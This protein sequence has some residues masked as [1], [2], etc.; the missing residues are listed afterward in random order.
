MAIQTEHVG[1]LTLPM[2]DREIWGH[3]IGMQPQV[4]GRGSECDLRLFDP[5]VSRAHALIWAESDGAI[6]VSDLSSSNGVHINGERLRDDCSPLVS[7]DVLRLGPN[8]A[9]CLQ[10]CDSGPSPSGMAHQVDMEAACSF[11]EMMRDMPFDGLTSDDVHGLSWRFQ[12]LFRESSL[13]TVW[14]ELATWVQGWTSAM[15]VGFVV[16]A[17]GTSDWKVC[18]SVGRPD[19]TTC[20]ELPIKISRRCLDDPGHNIQATSTDDDGACEWSVA[21]PIRSCGTTTAIYAVWDRR[22]RGDVRNWLSLIQAGAELVTRLAEFQH[23]KRCGG[24][25]KPSA[26]QASSVTCGQPSALAANHALISRIAA[27]DINILICGETGVGKEVLAREIHDQSGRRGP[28]VACHCGAIPEALVEDHL[29]GHVQGAFTG[30][31]REHRGY[32]EQANE[33][34]LFLDEI[35]DTPPAMQVKLLR[36]IQDK[37]FQPVGSEQTI[38]V[39]LRVIAAS[40]RDLQQMVLD[41]DFREDLYFRLAEE[42]IQVPPLRDRTDELSQLIEDALSRITITEAGPWRLTNAA[43]RK[44]MAYDWPGNIRE[45]NSVVRRATVR[46]E[47]ALIDAPHIVFLPIAKRTSDVSMQAASHEDNLKQHVT[48]V[49]KAAK[50]NKTQAAR[51]LGVDRGTVRR[52]VQ[53]WSRNE[54]T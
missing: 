20:W 27:T 4:I 45:L 50:G 51:V 22:S 34:T 8:T 38:E 14:K 13:R 48:N 17:D 11:A 42:L 9:F 23:H 44:L 10:T 5:S 43:R 30:A 49:L 7:G 31:D 37:Q 6:F 19:L 28:F 21:I 26:E 1:H 16:C 40:H 52:W 32:F 33:G 39:N 25:G 18:E 47:N 2:L 35:G 54:Q 15:Q 3:P 36:A 46:A 53:A 12:S 24:N 29:F 41:A